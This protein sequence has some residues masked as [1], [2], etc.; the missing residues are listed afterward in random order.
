MDYMG[1]TGETA[2][3]IRWGFV[4]SAVKPGRCRGR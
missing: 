3:R 1:Y 2:V 4:Q